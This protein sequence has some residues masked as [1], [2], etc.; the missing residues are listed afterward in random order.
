MEYAY[1]R[2]QNIQRYTPKPLAI[3]NIFRTF[4]GS[5]NLLKLDSYERI[6]FNRRAAF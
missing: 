6:E 1:L 3:S 5:Y 4:V 2:L